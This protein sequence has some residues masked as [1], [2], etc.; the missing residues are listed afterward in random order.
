MRYHVTKLNRRHAWHGQFAYMIEFSRAVWGGSGVLDFDRS[1]R[2]FNQTFG[3]SQDVEIRSELITGRDE[4]LAWQ[5]SLN[6]T[7]EDI[8]SHWT[9][10]AKYRDYRIYLAGE[11]ELNW[12]VL[13]HPNEA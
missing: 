10:S 2:W 5:G 8:N 1:R 11:S 7:A 6:Y 9:Y 3:W 12:F 4:P 13:S